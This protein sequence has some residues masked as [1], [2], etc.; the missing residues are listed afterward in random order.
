MNTK[1]KEVYFCTTSH[2]SED[3][4]IGIGTKI[5]QN[6]QVREGAKIGMNCN[7]SK[8]TFIGN[9]CKIQNGVS[10]EDDVFIG[11]NACFSNDKVPRAFN[12]DWKITP[13]VVKKG[14][15]IGANATIVCG[16]TIGK[17]AMV[18]A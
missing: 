5:W 1:F 7:I 9:N 10:I 12:V 11:P 18:A 13:T 15:S 4:E 14:V 3:S 17:Y 6:V 16:V 8:D 2:V